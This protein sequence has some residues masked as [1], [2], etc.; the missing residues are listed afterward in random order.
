MLAHA[1]APGTF[2]APIVDPQA[3]VFSQTV[4]KSG[5][6]F[7]RFTSCHRDAHN[8]TLLRKL[9]LGIELIVEPPNV[10]GSLLH[11][12]RSRISRHGVTADILAFHA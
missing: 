3:F 9:L 1:G 8:K 6:L 4:H 5:V 12:P 2:L 10:G 7:G 11:A